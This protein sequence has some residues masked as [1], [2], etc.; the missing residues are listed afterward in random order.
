MANFTGTTASETFDGTEFNDTAFGNGGN[1]ILNGNGSDDTLQLGANGTSTASGGAGNDTL[2]VEGVGTGVKTLLGGENDDR[3]NISG[4]AIDYVID[5]GS[6]DDTL[7]LFGSA[8][9]VDFSRSSVTGV[10]HFVGS[11]AADTI[12]LM[13][14]Q[15]VTF[16]TFDA[17]AGTDT[18]KLKVDGVV[19]A[20]AET[21][22]EVLNVEVIQ[23]FGGAGD[24]TFTVNVEQFTGINAF[25]LSNGA[26]TLN[27]MTS[28]DV[29]FTTRF[30]TLSGVETV[31]LIGTSGTIR[32]NVA[33]FS[34][35]SSISD[36]LNVVLADTGARLKLYT[37]AQIGALAA[38]G[39]DSLDATD[40]ILALTVAQFRELGSVAL[41]ATDVVT[42]AD[43]G[44][45]LATLTTTELIAA[46]AAGVDRI[47]A[48]NNVLSLTVDQYRALVGEIGLTA[49][50]VITLADTGENLA[51]LSLAEI[52]ALT[53]NFIDKLDATDG[54]LT[55]SLQKIQAL[56]KVALT[57]SDV[58]TAT[59]TGAEFAA[60]TTT[61]IR[62]LGTK[63]VDFF[64]AT[65]DVVFFT[66]N[67]YL[68]LVTIKVVSSDEV[69]LRDSGGQLIALTPAQFAGLADRGFD[70]IDSTTDA[71]TLSA[72]QYGALGTVVLTAGDVVL[73]RDTGAAIGSLSVVE[74]Q[75]LVAKGIDKI[76]ATDNV[77]TVN[78]AKVA[79]LVPGMLTTSDVVTLSDTGSAIAAM[80]VADIAGLAAKFIDRIDSVNGVLSLTVAQ[81]QALGTVTLTADDTITLADT[82][83]NL[84][85]LSGSQL[86]ALAGK[87]IDR[88]DATDNALSLTLAKLQA[89][90]TVALV[91]AD[92]VTLADT[93]TVLNALTPAE[94]SALAGRGVDRI[95]SLNNT[96]TWSLAQA[97]ALGTVT[98]TA[99]DVVTVVGTGA[100]I[101]ALTSAQ[102]STL[103][104]RGVDRLDASDDVL[105]LTRAQFLALGAMTVAA[106]DVVVLADTSGALLGLTPAQFGAMAAAG[107]DRIDATDNVVILSAAQY[108]GLGSVA[109]TAGDTVTLRDTGANIAALSAAVFAGLAAKGVDK[110]DANDN[111]LALTVAQVEGLAAGMLT[112]S[113]VVTL[114]D[115]GATISAQAD[116][117]FTGL[118]GKGVDR[119]DATDDVLSLTVAKYLGLGT[120]AL[121]LA[122]VVTLADSGANLAA[123]SASQ[124][125]ALAGKG[126]D[127]IDATNNVLSLTFA[128]LQA[129]G[130]V[131]LAAGDTVTLADTTAA[132]EAM[133]VSDIAALAGKGVDR[134]DSLNNTL[135]LSVA[136]GDALGDVLLTASDFV[137]AADTSTELQAL[138]VGD[139]A[140]LAGVLVDRID[141]TDNV[142]TLTLAKLQALG[143]VALTPA[144]VV[145]L[146]DT[147]TVLNALTPEEIAALAAKGIDQIN[148]TDDALTLSV[149]QYR[150]LGTIALTQADYVILADTS[151]NLAT[152]T[153]TE[154]AALTAK[155]IDE[156][157]STGGTTVETA[158]ATFKLDDGIENLTFIGE[159]SFTGTGNDIANTIT[160]GASGDLLSG[161]GANDTLVGLDGDDLLIG[162]L[163][164]DVL[165]GGAGGDYASY[166]NA[167]AG[168]TVSLADPSANTG[169]ALGDTFISIERIEGSAFNDILTGDAGDNTL[170]G[171]LGADTLN[172]G[173][174]R[175]TAS[176]FTA[177]AGLAVSLATPGSN[178]GEAAGD[179]Y[180]SIE[181]ISG[182]AFDDN[183]TGDAG[184]NF[185]FGNGGADQ[186]DGGAGFDYASYRNSTAGVT[187]FLDETI[188]NTGEAE[189]DTY[190]SIEGLSGS[191]FD[192]T[193][194]GN[195]ANN[196]LEGGLGF[197]ILNGG[198][199]VDW[200]GYFNATSGVRA[201]LLEPWTNTGEAADA[202]TSI[203]GLGGS[204][205]DDILIG[206][207]FDNYLRGGLG[208]D[209][210]DA[211]NGFDFAEYQNATVGVTASLANSAVNT[212]EAAGDTYV[213]IEGIIGTSFDD[214]LIGN[215]LDNNWLI[216]LGGADY[217][218]GGLGNNDFAAYSNATGPV[219]ASL[220]DPSAN[221]GDAA[222]DTYVSIESLSGTSF[223]DIL[224]GDSGNNT[225]RGRLGADQLIG[226]DG[227][228]VAEY[229]NSTIGLTVT[230]DTS[231][232]ISNT[233]EAA[234]DTFIS[235]EGL[236]GSNFSDTLVGDS[237]NNTLSGRSGG[238]ILFGGVGNDTFYGNS[239]TGGLDGSVDRVDYSRVTGL[240]Q[241]IVVNWLAGS[242]VGQ[243]GI[244]DTDSMFQIESV[245]GTAFVDTFDATGFTNTS[246]RAGDFGGFQF[247]QGGGGNDIII[248]NNNT[249]AFYGDATSAVT[250][251]LSISGGVYG[252]T[253]TGGGVGTDQVTNVNRFVGSIYNDVFWGTNNVEIFDGYNG[254]DDVYHG[255]GG[256]DIVEFDGGARE[257][258]DVNMAAGTI[259]GRAPGSNIGNDTLDSIERI[260]GSEYADR[261]DATGFSGS[262]TNA[263]S[264][265]T[266][267]R[268]EGQ[269]GA[270]EV[271]GNGN[272]YLDYFNTSAAVTVTTTGQGVGTAT[273]T[274]GSNTA[275]DTFTG[276][277]A[278]NGGNSND[279]FN[280]GSGADLFFG[281]NGN[282]FMNGGAGDDTLEGG[283]GADS[284]S[285]GTG[286]DY[287]QYRNAGSAVSLIL[288]SG[289]FAGDAL[290]DHFTSI[291]GAIGSNFND[292][293][294][295]SNV[296]NILMGGFGADTLNGGAGDHMSFDDTDYASYANSNSGLTVS[297]QN[298]SLNT[299]E[300]FGDTFVNINGLIG[301]NF[302]DVLTGSDA[303]NDVFIGGFGNDTLNGMAGSD[304]ARYDAATFGI[305]VD[306][307]AGLVNGGAGQDTLLSI[308]GIWGSNLADIYDASAY[309]AGTP[310]APHDDYNFFEGFGGGDTITGASTTNPGGIFATSIYYTQAT[311]GIWVTMTGAAAGNVSATYG[312]DTSVDTFTNVNNVVGSNFNDTFNGTSGTQSFDGGAGGDVLFGG[313]DNDS[314]AG[315]DG[316]DQLSGGTGDDFLV[317][318]A[319]AD[320]LD[321]GDGI[322]MVSY[323]EFSPGGGGVIGLTASL[324][325]SSINTGNAAGDTY[326]S[327]EN[328][329]GTF[330]NDTLVGNSGN[331]I[332][333]GVFGADF[334]NG[335]GG[336]D[337]LRGL[338]G[339]DTYVFDS[340]IGAGNLATI[341]GYAHG[342]DHFNLDNAIFTQ[343]GLEGGLDA[344]VFVNGTA[345]LDSNDRIIFD[346]TTGNVSYD[347]D[348]VG[349]AAAVVFAKIENLSG[350]PLDHTD[351]LIV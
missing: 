22:P 36:E 330:G 226:G 314:L 137:T 63:G 311:A 81:Y 230:L 281:G 201:S 136:K 263:G 164:A 89:L 171:G 72:A 150:A 125:A 232:S 175:D 144:D 213:N 109:L 300:A 91:A 176:Y 253:A 59:A 304:L 344:F 186:I 52:A 243:A 212:G 328:L 130:T 117:F 134:I 64:D 312:A 7:G 122:D 108:L 145:T 283:T 337:T 297:L 170:R 71:L 259:T 180:V 270:D 261:Y 12:T 10:E 61:D 92:V 96:L 30:P 21:K 158:L 88:I 286:F 255:G 126:V 291:E 327:I 29:D 294:T 32:M 274:Y 324:E 209:Y 97:L 316:S 242:V 75:E 152:L 146:A 338:G 326:V 173:A 278:V 147:S 224:I 333:D 347:A 184:D 104:A 225:F 25:F 275:T 290:G 168:L 308:E 190:I 166:R 305:H 101:A 167:T 156:V 264:N 339:G 40:D 79:G 114:A 246:A 206:D 293:L 334:F 245:F 258:I 267:N 47:D 197:D 121:T 285:G 252:G 284:L 219:T 85:A 159:G 76:D 45:N 282:D 174:G 211:G 192:D 115:A 41:T 295:G 239:A 350:G 200:A 53:P 3:I 58:V 33:Q 73:L 111:A 250:V 289:G 298:S 178:S 31:N 198:A 172:G 248:G 240:S 90:G 199:G 127:A 169:E 181:N 119:V 215:S 217:L 74:F 27:V 83:A 227:L 86:A 335:R 183:L 78:V 346:S 39:V 77:L 14:S 135:T 35:F 179:T 149:A 55:L 303:F 221:T 163:G 315:G 133:S 351:F 257:A 191:N 110:V 69:V 153:P 307:A 162:G 249:E 247:I 296:G 276:V 237:G 26:D 216:G 244:I 272:T 99:G 48:T 9:V 60:L 143:T 34:K 151:A 24:D 11:N 238:D 203:E 113:D 288:A 349:G 154:N 292:T 260:R 299:G 182:S 124:L 228:D 94:I 208:A 157:Q 205:F 2:N 196:W 319:G 188:H 207:G 218:D 155:G 82:G 148:A 343:V 106:G 318:G 43:T 273:A 309:T 128:K 236:S 161:L 103:A 271:I 65:D 189:G 4:T 98:L 50:D 87:G 329:A 84:A 287:V 256:T 345:A 70:R 341:V 210:L 131:T 251:T 195:A 140:S 13:A 6:G 331:N 254:G 301:S 306:M 194:V 220:A 313:A 325:N 38:A 105:T 138:T 279:T 302:N 123:L 49:K 93:A 19:D 142:L 66:K 320:V 141:A 23:V 193:L 8:T 18:V 204:R 223:D 202:Y 269:G 336:M 120:V 16:D 277:A 323:Y 5:G 102:I 17:G 56:D 20:S 28:G 266:F 177:T 118:A 321:G 112:A 332:I 280:G 51:D 80:S 116:A 322:D 54:V 129:L 235:I 46:A 348:G 68:A 100:E 37:P 234:G 62:L 342:Q 185:L 132:L 268:F 262:S 241:G 233:G 57:A 214:V 187:A 15:F 1:D 265:G 44:A 67:Q 222:G 317:G 160:G 231:L 229:L 139:L 165:N 340:T 107:I 310:G 42:L 95:D